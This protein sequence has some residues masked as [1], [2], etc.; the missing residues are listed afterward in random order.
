MPRRVTA[1]APG[2][3]RVA[4]AGR[5]VHSGGIT[6]RPAMRGMRAMASR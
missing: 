6:V 5:S 1:E 4:G 2:A 3:R